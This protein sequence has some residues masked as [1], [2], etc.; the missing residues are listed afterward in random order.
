MIKKLLTC[1]LLA[2]ST[3]A[4]AHQGGTYQPTVRLGQT[5]RVND[6]RITP[7][8]VI[9]DSRCPMNARCIW[10]GRVLITA[11][12]GDGNHVMT[13]QLEL[14]KPLM[15]RGR[16]L[17]LSDVAPSRYAGGPARKLRYRFTFTFAPPLPVT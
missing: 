16:E 5:A 1:S 12:I 9:E 17:E 6:L 15:I 3:P 2:L 10:A 8:R 7:I 4:F 14:G 11:R 13:R